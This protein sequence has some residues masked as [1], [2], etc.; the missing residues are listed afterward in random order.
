MG[1]CISGNGAAYITKRKPNNKNKKTVGCFT[2]L[3]KG[4]DDIDI[5]N[6][7]SSE[8]VPIPQIKSSFNFYHKDDKLNTQLNSLIEKYKDGLKIQK[9]NFEQIFNIFMNYTYDFT[10]SN[11]IIY[12]TRE[13]SS[14]KNQLFLKKFPQINYNIKQ[15]EIMKKEKMMKFFNFLKGKN[16]IFILKDESSLDILE[17]FIIFFMTNEGKLSLQNIFILSQYIHKN[18]EVNTETNTDNI[19]EDFL[20]YFIDED[21]LYGY[22]PKILINSNDIKSSSLNY[23]TPNLNFGYIFFDYFPH[24]KKNEFNN[25]NK[26]N[27]DKMK[28]FNK[29]D[30]NYL[31]D[32]S[33]HNFDIF[34]NF[35]SKF[36][37]VYIM[38]FISRDEFNSIINGKNSGFIN[39]IN[40][41]RNKINKEDKHNSIKQKNIFIPKNIEFDEYY[42]TIHN[43]LIPLIEELK[44]QMIQ[45][46]CILIQFDN[47]VDNLFLLKLIYIIVFR[48]TGLTFD[49][50][51][52]YLKWNFFE[53]GNESFM[54]IK[55]NDIL[56]FLV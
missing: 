7:I 44:Q 50:I 46:N 12:D 13:L 14:E 22:S 16:L 27:N 24:I 47:D 8:I 9:I 35:V 34:L 4:E 28:T 15:L 20:Y 33:T 3:C 10:K 30:I 41:K 2:S 32:K 53:I 19:Y 37:I 18:K 38:N 29:F 42:K 49:N 45:N 52:N 23:N 39:S 25:Y 31:N 48:I 40:G 55:K 43:E 5:D 21:L 51:Y 6:K 54:K 26:K 17:K 11:F 1:S 56:N 36:K